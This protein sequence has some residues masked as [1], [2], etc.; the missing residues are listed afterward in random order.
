M[1]KKRLVASLLSFVMLTSSTGC[2]LNNHNKNEAIH[3]TVTK[4]EFEEQTK[5]VEEVTEPSY[6]EDDKMLYTTCNVNLREEDNTSSNIITLVDEYNKLQRLE[7]NG[8]WNY[9]KY[10][11]DYGYVS[12][13]YTK[14]LTD[15]YVEVDISSQNLKLYNQNEKIYSCDIVSG[16]KD[17]YDTRLGCNPIYTHEKNRYLKGDDY[18]VYVYF[19]MGFDQGIGIHDADNWRHG[20]YGN[21]IYKTNG[22]HGCVSVSYS[23]AEF[24]YNNTNNN[25]L[26]LVHK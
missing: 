17:K 7:T 26:V 25:D 6:I 12:C 8:I 16:L 19:W 13:E 15:T 18:K 24:I 10:K 2:T 20:N 3:T 14:E 4:H 1:K 9:V 5:L 21:D 23:D 22:S 11:D